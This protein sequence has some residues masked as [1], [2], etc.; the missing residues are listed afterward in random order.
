MSL[1]YTIINSVSTSRTANGIRRFIVQLASYGFSLN[2]TSRFFLI[3]KTL[4]TTYAFVQTTPP[5][6]RTQKQNARCCGHVVQEQL[7]SIKKR[8]Q[9]KSAG[10]ICFPKKSAGAR[11]GRVIT[12]AG[13]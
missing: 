6:P 10:I 7:G 1:V 8:E 9:R 13:R 4:E 2:H 11:R 3:N 12:P 5:P